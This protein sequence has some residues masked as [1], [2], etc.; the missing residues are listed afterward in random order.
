MRP[1]ILFVV[2]A[3]G[4]PKAPPTP[5][6]APAAFEPTPATG[7]A[8]VATVNA[9]PVWGACVAAQAARGATRQVALHQCVDFELMAQAAEARGLATNPEV[10]RATRTAMVSQLVAKAYEDGFTQPSQF[11][12]DWD[13]IVGKS[14]WRVRH[15]DYRAS[16]YAR[17]TVPETATPAQ[18]EA[19]HQ[20]ALHVAA[21]LAHE[22]G[23]LGASF[24]DLAQAAAGP[25]KLDRGDVPPYRAGALDE[26]YAQ[27]LFAIPAVGDVS[28]A[29]RTKW[30]WDVI[31]WTDDVPA[32]APTDA[33][34]AAQM[35][36][37]VKR[38][39]FNHWVDSIQK[40]L[41]VHVELV[42]ANVE[43]LEGMPP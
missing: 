37:D 38:V 4:S 9:R 33:E 41:D 1:W 21:A 14:L 24:G 22:H 8:I 27:A 25:T 5:V 32:A 16:T 3:C 7:D 12:A 36:P 39:Y 23:L 28:P 18:D 13:A 19:A 10:V 31:A 17:V 6:G 11:G 2:V 15:E 40:S 30:G 26:H 34:V 35:L 42:P 20:V 43:R 29:V